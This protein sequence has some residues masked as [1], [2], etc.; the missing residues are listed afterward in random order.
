MSL[1]SIPLFSALTERMKW[2]SQRQS[3]L[4]QNIANSDT[5]G[6]RASDLKPQSFEDLVKGSKEAKVYMASTSEGHI[7]NEQ[8]K[9]FNPKVE[10]EHYE[11]TPAG[12]AVVLEDQMMKLADTQMQYQ[13]TTSLYKKQVGLLKTAL[14]RGR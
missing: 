12:N 2:L 1:K 9:P 7:V 4:S 6:Y 5:P 3:V 11:V 14:G 13:M 10:R 8:K